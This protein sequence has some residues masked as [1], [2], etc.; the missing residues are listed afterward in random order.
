MCRCRLGLSGTNIQ[1]QS[2][3]WFTPGVRRFIEAFFWQRAGKST[4]L[5]N[6]RV[7][8]MSFTQL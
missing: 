5:E 2:R 1:L 8:L 7:E 6:K 4:V 3:Y